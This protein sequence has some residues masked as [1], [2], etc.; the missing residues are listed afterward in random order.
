[1]LTQQE[2]NSINGAFRDALNSY[3]SNAKE[4]VID[5]KATFSTCAQ[6]LRSEQVE[7]S[8]WTHRNIW[9]A[10]ILAVHDQLDKV[11]VKSREQTERERRQ[12]DSAAGRQ[13]Y[14]TNNDGHAKPTNSL[15][16]IAEKA[17]K[18]LQDIFNPQSEAPKTDPKTEWPTFEVDFEAMDEINRKK[19]LRLSKEDTRAWMKRRVVVKHRQQYGLD[20]KEE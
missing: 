12:A 18:N 2:V 13:R 20:T 15:A 3:N 5:S 11:P 17:Q 4:K 8:S 9:A 16:D 19:F 7:Q 1:M 10:A 14:I 6:Y